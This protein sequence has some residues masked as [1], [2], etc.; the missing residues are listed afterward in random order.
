MNI[1][2]LSTAQ[3]AAILG[4]TRQAVLELVQRGRIPASK[5]GFSYILTHQDVLMYQQQKAARKGGK[6]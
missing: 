6:R 4:V 1:E 3:A 2:L 5:V